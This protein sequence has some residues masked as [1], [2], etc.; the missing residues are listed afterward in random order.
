MAEPEIYTRKATFETQHQFDREYW[1]M[2][3]P[4]AIWEAASRMTDD[5]Y[6]FKGIP[7]SERLFQRTIVHIQRGKR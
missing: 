7:E 2:M 5:Y 3:G 4:A 6:F 1:R